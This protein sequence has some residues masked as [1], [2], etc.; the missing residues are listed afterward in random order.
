MNGTK[1]CLNVEQVGA[2]LGISRPKAYELVHRDDFP[3]IV[4]GRRIIVPREAFEAWLGDQ[5]H[6]TATN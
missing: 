2:E 1:T 4:L 3:K 5:V 6:A